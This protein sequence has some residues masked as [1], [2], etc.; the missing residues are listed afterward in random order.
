MSLKIMES[1]SRPETISYRHNLCSTNLAYNLMNISLTLIL[2]HISRLNEDHLVV[3][4]TKNDLRF[5]IKLS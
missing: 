2:A 5:F 3:L 1:C 4:A